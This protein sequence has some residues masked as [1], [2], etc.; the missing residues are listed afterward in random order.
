MLTKLEILEKLP[1]A[2]KEERRKL[3]KLARELDSDPIVQFKN[4]I[5]HGDCFEILKSIPDGSIDAVIT[6]PPYMTTDLHFDKAGLM[7]IY[8]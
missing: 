6:D 4:Q 8:S 1:T 2:T 5:I 7:L 3:L